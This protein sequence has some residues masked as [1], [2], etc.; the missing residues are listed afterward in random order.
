[1]T[2]SSI[3]FMVWNSFSLK[4]TWKSCKVGFVK[5]RVPMLI[6]CHG[7]GIVNNAFSLRFLDKVPSK[8]RF[9]WSISV[10]CLSIL[11][12]PGS[13]VM[14]PGVEL[15]FVGEDNVV[16]E[17][18]PEPLASVFS[19]KLQESNNESGPD[20]GFSSEMLVAEGYRF[21]HMESL[22]E[23]VERIHSVS[24]DCASGKIK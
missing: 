20:K 14:R 3:Y 8:F 6:G 12:R 9:Q 2:V 18:I 16:S 10:C 24:Q 23:R 19:R 1:M 22:P 7:N 13:S 5:R 11:L 4:L 17:Q 15:T 21:V